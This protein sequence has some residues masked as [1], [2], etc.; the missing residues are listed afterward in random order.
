MEVTKCDLCRKTVSGK[1]YVTV[2]YRGSFVHFS[3]CEKCGEPI[4]SF[5][6]KRMKLEEVKMVIEQK[7]YDSKSKKDK[8]K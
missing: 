3:F 2:F 7:A 8:K 5:L 4:I 1:K 6:R